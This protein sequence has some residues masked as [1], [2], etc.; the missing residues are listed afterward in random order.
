MGDVKKVSHGAQQ[1]NRVEKLQKKE[2]IS[3]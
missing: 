1:Q 3:L 2:S